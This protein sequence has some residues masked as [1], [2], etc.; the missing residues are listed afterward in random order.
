MKISENQLESH[1]A[2]ATIQDPIEQVTTKTAERESPLQRLSQNTIS[3]E[4]VVGLLHKY[5]LLS[6]LQRELIID[7]EL[8]SIKCTEAEIF[9]AY[10]AFYQQ[11][12]INSDQDRAT[13]LERNRVTLPQLE[14]LVVR[15]IKL[16]QFKRET[17][18]SKVDTYFLQRK[19]DL[20][21][22]SYSLLRVKDLHLAQ[23][24]FFR[25]QDG[26]ASFAEVAQQYSGGQEAQM[27][28]TIALH[29]LS[30]IHPTLAQKVRSIRVGELTYPIQ[31]ADWFTIVKLEK[32]LP[33]QLDDPMRTRL[34]EELFDRWIQSKIQATLFPPA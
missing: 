26:E 4:E 5:G 13:W 9:G 25:I 18:A 12:Q 11:Q 30:V 17:F 33:A 15:T 23:E 24:L 8:E 7:A 21:R 29:E 1:I 14:H 32:Y 10:K 19:D 20:D 34:I 6:Q 3:G 27:G 22:A 2:I 28:G 16:D 31:I